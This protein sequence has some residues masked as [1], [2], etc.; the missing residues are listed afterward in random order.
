MRN[1]SKF[2]WIVFMPIILSL[3]TGLLYFLF[4]PEFKK[5]KII[6]KIYVY[7]DD[8]HLLK[9]RYL[10]AYNEEVQVEIKGKEF[11]IYLPYAYYH[12][13]DWAYTDNTNKGIELLASTIIKIRQ[14][15]L[16]RY[17]EGE[18]HRMQMFKFKI[19][20]EIK[21]NIV[22]YYGSEND[23]TRKITIIID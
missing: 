14:P 16:S 1:I 19:V 17:R 3:L 23:E 9:S 18:D 15:I 4:I 7:I 21:G 8:S 2:R 6:D 20:E 11:K 5:S 12:G 13:S 22:F 10:V